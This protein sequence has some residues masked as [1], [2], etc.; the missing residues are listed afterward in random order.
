MASIADDLTIVR[1]MHTDAFN[2]DPAVTFIPTGSQIPGRPTIGAW[3]TYGLGSE[4]Q[5]LPGFVV[6]ISGGGQP[7]GSHYWGSGFLPSVYQGVKFRSKGDPVLFVSN[8]EWIDPVGTRH[9]RC[10]PGFERSAGRRRR[11]P[12]ISTRIASYEMAYRM[13]TSVPELMDI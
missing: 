5:D 6:L 1:S 9:S 12:E 13:Q 11:R 7:L 2:H 10:H 3:L 8:P 4:A